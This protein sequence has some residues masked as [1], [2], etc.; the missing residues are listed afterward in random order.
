MSAYD[1]KR[2]LMMEEN[3]RG[4]GIDTGGLWPKADMSGFGLL[5]R[6]S[7]TSMKQ[8]SKKRAA[9][10]P[11]RSPRSRDPVAIGS[12]ILAT[13]LQFERFRIDDSDGA[14]TER[15]P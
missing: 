5:A 1:P 14:L 12:R 3:A 7:R 8:T 15:T 2:T 11:G 9:V 4:V 10:H 13:I 6:H